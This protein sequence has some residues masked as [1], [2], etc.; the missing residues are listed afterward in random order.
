MNAMFFGSPD[1]FGIEIGELITYPDFPGTYIQ[2][3]FWIGNVAIGD[4]NDRISLIASIKSAFEVC[5]AEK[6]RRLTPFDNIQTTELFKAVYEAYFSWDYTNDP[7]TWRNLSAIYHLDRIGMGAIEDKYGLIL[8]A[9]QE[10]KERVVVKDLKQDQFVADVSI[11]LGF[12][13]STLGDYIA[14]GRSRL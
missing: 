12:I 3:R 6:E 11:T 13:E 1:N 5:E 7:V 8:V 9:T 4:W 14:W 2:F 10:G